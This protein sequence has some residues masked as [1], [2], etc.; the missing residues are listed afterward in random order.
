M[1]KSLLSLIICLGLCLTAQNVV[2]NSDFAYP[3]G[4]GALFWKSSGE[5]AGLRYL[6]TETGACFDFSSETPKT[7]F[8]R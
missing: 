8:I 7:L 3:A 2:Q 4:D 1:R 6:R 5:E